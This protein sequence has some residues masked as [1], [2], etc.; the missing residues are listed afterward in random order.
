[1]NWIILTNRLGVDLRNPSAHDIEAAVEDLQDHP[2]D[3][4]H[5]S[6]ILRR[7]E[8]DGPLHVLELIGNGSMIYSRYSDSDFED[9]E[10]ERKMEGIG[11]KDIF[12]RF[13]CL[14]EGLLAELNQ[15]Q[16]SE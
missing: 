13:D 10:E 7:G 2:N 11:I 16:W 14:R 8:D 12:R 1:M 9:L 3:Q 4:E 15:C 6:V 5:G